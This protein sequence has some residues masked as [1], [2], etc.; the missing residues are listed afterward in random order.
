MSHR[1]LYPVARKTA[2]LCQV[3]KL[4]PERVLRRAGLPPDYLEYETKGVPAEQFF[5]LFNALSEE[6]KR[7]DLSLFL[8]KLYA[9]G[10]FVPE[11][12][13]FSCSAN[14][15]QGLTRLGLFKPLIAPIRLDIQRYEDRLT[16]SF[17]KADSNEPLPDFMAMFEIVYF[18]E[19]CR[20]FTAE[21]ITPLAIDLP[22]NVTAN[23]NELAFFGLAPRTAAVPAIH[24]SLEDAT[25]PL[26]SANDQMLKDILKDLNRRLA[27]R[28]RQAPVTTRV[29]NVLVEMLP[30][31]QSSV[32]EACHRLAM[33]KRSLQRKLKDEDTSF[34]AVLETVRS[35]LSLHYLKQQEMTVEEISYLLAYR[36]PNSFYRAFHG[37]TGMTPMQAR[38]APPQNPA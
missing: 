21:H 28:T 14:I 3:L 5:T 11:L 2:Q 16:L 27:A 33:S 10:P 29:K 15:E 4:S 1:P 34:Q 20:T 19:R 30:S 36:D 31:G 26:I 17:F 38:H 12:F 35:E 13:A 6:A 25:R 32:E 9:H 22:E 8:G 24:L 37:W 7:D 18:L 23:S